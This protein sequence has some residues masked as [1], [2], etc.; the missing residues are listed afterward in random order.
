MPQHRFRF[1]LPCALLLGA[2]LCAALPSLAAE[3]AGGSS[4]GLGLGLGYERSPYRDFDDKARLLPILMYES[5]WISVAG[6]GLDLKLLPET[7]PWS[8]RL[9]ARYG[10]DGY[11]AEDSPHLAGMAERK[12]GAWLGG[13]LGWQGGLGRLSAELLGDASGHS[14]GRQLRL[15]WE[16]RYAFGRVDL[17]PRLAAVSLDRKYVDYYYGV[18]AGEARAGRAA[19][20]GDSAVNVELGLRL[21]YQ[22]APGQILFMDLGATRLGSAIQDSPLVERRIVPGLRVG[23]LYRF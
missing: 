18:R 6:P 17:T 2:G 21:G 7:G 16:R 8:L 14:K 10:F 4:W 15:Q 13:A 19:H 11:E 12:G 22:A 3:P 5:R 23:Y 9:R 20:A 1:S